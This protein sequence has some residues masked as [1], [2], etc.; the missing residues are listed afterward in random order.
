MAVL[1]IGAFARRASVSIKTLRHYDRAGV[2]R[3][4]YVD[5]HSGYRYYE[6]HQL[7]ALQELR[8][9]RALGCSVANLR[10]WTA[11]GQSNLE[12][13]V[14]LLLHLRGRLFH[15]LDQ[16][17]QRLVAIDCW[18][19]QVAGSEVALGPEIP[20]E[21][22]IPDTPAYTLRDR[23][24]VAD[25]AVYKMFEAAERVVA[26]QQARTALQPFLLLHDK[27]Y[28]EKNADVEVCIPIH[29]A[30]LT[31]LGGSI[32]KGAPRAVCLGFSGRYH[33][34]PAALRVIEQWMRLSGVSAAG[35]LRESYIR[36]GADQQGY[37][38][39][40]HCVASSVDDYLTELQLPFAQA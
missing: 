27:N 39:A 20:T 2:F 40:G 35:P 34:A 11:A 22:S 13:R 31:A 8:M 7:A 32:V 9:L 15:R 6:T 16:D 23:V 19:Q 4:A 21:R 1:R 26:Q 29:S 28:R 38:L 17:L 5:P 3:P 36:F 25:T 10:S 12:S 18:I 37:K 30:A 33:R 14:A 24:R